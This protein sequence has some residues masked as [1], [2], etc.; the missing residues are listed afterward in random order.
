MCDFPRQRSGIGIPAN[1]L[2]LMFDLFQRATNTNKIAGSGLGLAICK[3]AVDI[4]GG[5]ITVESQVDV[6]TTFTVTID[7]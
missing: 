5:R 1:E 6:G 4:H 2:D 7:C 3:Q